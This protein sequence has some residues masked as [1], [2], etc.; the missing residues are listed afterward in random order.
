MSGSLWAI[1]L[2]MNPAIAARGQSSSDGR[3]LMKR[4]PAVGMF[5]VLIVLSGLHALA[6]PNVL[7]SIKS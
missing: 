7:A 2:S 4:T 6:T 3:A 5:S 1:S